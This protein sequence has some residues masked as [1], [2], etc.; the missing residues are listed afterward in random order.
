Q[1]HAPVQEILVELPIGDRFVQ[2]K[3]PQPIFYEGEINDTSSAIAIILPDTIGSDHRWKNIAD[4]GIIQARW[5]GDELVVRG[6]SQRELLNSNSQARIS[7]D[8]DCCNRCLH[9]HNQR[10]WNQASPLYGF[11]VIP[12]GYCPVFEPIEE[13]N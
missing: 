5:Q 11:K 1:I 8:L 4:T 7:S 13:G 2:P 3:V 10:C 12:E 9:Y 6:I